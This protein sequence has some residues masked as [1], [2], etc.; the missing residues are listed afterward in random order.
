MSTPSEIAFQNRQ[1]RLVTPLGPKKTVLLSAEIVE[2]MSE[3]TAT[4]VDFLSYDIDLDIGA[5]LGQRFTIEI[6]LDDGSVRKWHGICTECNFY[7]TY[8]GFAR[9]RAT[10]RPWL[11]LLTRRGTSRVFQN[12]TALD[13]VKKVFGDAGFSDFRVA[14]RATYA[15]IEYL[16]QYNE[17]DFDFITRL[18]SREGIYYFSE[19]TD[20]TETI[21]LLDDVQAL[22]PLPQATTIEFYFREEKYR[23]DTDHIFEWVGGQTVQTGAVAVKSFNYQTATSDLK[24]VVSIPVG[25]H[26]YK[27]FEVY[28]EAENYLDTTEGKRLARLRQEANVC[29]HARAHG[30]ANVRTM[31]VGGTFTLKLHP[32]AAMNA[33]YAIIAATHVLKIETDYDDKRTGSEQKEVA[34]KGLI[35]TYR[36]DFEVQ[37]KTVAYRDGPERREPPKMYGIYT[38]TV[39]GPSGEEVFTDDYGRVKVKFPW[40]LNTATDDTACSMWVRVAHGWAGSLW[41]M[42]HIPRIGQEVLIQFEWGNP[43]YPIVTGMVYNSRDKPPYT[44]ESTPTQTGVKTNSS[45]GGGG[46][47]ELV[48]EDKKGEEFV[49]FQSE[50]D[51]MSTIKNNATFSVGFEKADPGDYT[52]KIKNHMTTTVE[53]GDRT[54][55]VKTGKET[56]S[57]KQDRTLTVEGNEI[58]NVTK[59]KTDT[60]KQ[61]YKIDVGPNLTITAK[62][63][64]V[65]E[66][67]GSTIEMTPDK[68]VMKSV[69]VEIEGSATLKAK[70]G[71]SANY[72]AGGQCVVKG[73]IVMI[74]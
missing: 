38:A 69:Q 57:V 1:L 36:C 27:A 55:T 7:G 52:E 5:L 3:P 39:V 46:F 47:H 45:K 64:I 70:G 25:T 6:D 26:T 51:Y 12:M 29:M 60:I 66:C 65:I 53:S 18:M 62:S 49:R 8:Q 72:E 44:P 61:D 63:K 15:T 17:T 42:Q 20:T 34:G 68:I 22:K 14:T 30:S 56:Y 40:D 4:T 41:G 58:V 35:D 9:F 73:A 48:F 50:K 54:F 10:L 16:I 11:W 28:R 74:N 33:E 59:N 19:Y 71:A 2:R 37:P 21:V 23:R 43:S 24:S 32:R 31:A 13:I 67:G